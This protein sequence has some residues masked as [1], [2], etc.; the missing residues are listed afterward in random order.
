MLQKIGKR[1]KVGRAKKKLGET[2]GGPFFF[3]FV[4]NKRGV[5][6]GTRKK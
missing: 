4:A 2:I 3:S 6:A 5:C 1:P